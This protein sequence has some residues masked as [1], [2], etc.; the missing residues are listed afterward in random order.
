[1]PIITRTLSCGMPLLVEP[2]SGVRSACIQWLLPAGSATDPDQL[3]GLSTMWAE[4]IFRGCGA[5]DSRQQADALDRLGITRGCD[6]STFHLRLSFTL[7]GDRIAGALPLMADMVLRPRMDADSIEPTRELALQAL[8]GLKDDPHQRAVLLARARHNPPP[9]HRS[10]MG[11]PETLAAITRDDLLSG[12][13]RQIRPGSHAGWNQP[14]APG[15]HHLGSILSVAGDID[16]VTDGPA[17][18]ADAIARIMDRLLAGWNGAPPPVTTSAPAARATYHHEPDVSSQVQIVLVHDAPPEPSAD[19]IIERIVSSVLSGGMASRLFTEVREKR[20]LCYSVSQTY[21][22]ERAYG[23]CMAYVGTTP[24]RAQQS[25]DVL[26]AE[27]DRIHKKDGAIT[28]DEFDR[29]MIGIRSGLV[30]SGEST[31]ARAGAIAG[32]YHRRGKAR[33]LDEVLASY[34]G[35]TLD[36]INAYL[37]RRRPGDTTIVTL[38]GASL[39]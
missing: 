1:M 17:R 2:M 21:A 14:A 4:L 38:G 7:L 18:G 24:E 15:T 34:G 5:L 22:T 20:G 35:V 31:G 28:G 39:Q 26:R 9:L 11:R 27:L 37:A 13:A 19:S 10:G 30:F 36:E 6:A 25:L 12:W 3:E 33:T 29:A 16:G 32:D 8:E 23:R